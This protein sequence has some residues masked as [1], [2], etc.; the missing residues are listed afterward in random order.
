MSAHRL[1]GRTLLTATTVLGTALT[2][3]AAA[4]A[5][6]ETPQSGYLNL[7][8]KPDNQARDARASLL[9]CN[10]NGGTHPHADAACK[11]L[12]AANGDLNQLNAE[13]ANAMCPMVN[14]PITVTAH[15]MWQNRSIRFEKTFSNACIAQ[16]ETGQVFQF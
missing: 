2:P 4:S 12:D 16:S 15:G 9:T 8:V 13:K 6:P 5:A 3:V 11:G 1:I 7:T 14:K 10:P